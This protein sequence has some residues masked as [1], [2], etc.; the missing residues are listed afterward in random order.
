MRLHRVGFGRL[1]LD[2]SREIDVRDE[3]TLDD[4]V[5]EATDA[6]AGWGEPTT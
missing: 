1:R 5:R 6:S 4:C 2:L 3:G